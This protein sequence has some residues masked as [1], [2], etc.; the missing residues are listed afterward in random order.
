MARTTKAIFEIGAFRVSFGA[1]G[2]VLKGAQLVELEP[3]T[4]ETADLRIHGGRIVA[5]GQVT[6]EPGDEIIE[7]DGHWVMP[8]LVSAQHQLS[9]TLFRG[10]AREAGFENE[11]LALQRLQTSLELDDL[12]AAAAAGGLEG[13]MSGTTTVFDVT[14][15]PRCVL[16]SLTRV[17]HGLNDVGLR[18]VIACE[19]SDR[20]G[21]L[22]REESLDETSTFG[23]RARGRFRGALAFAH[24]GGISDDALYG[25]SSLLEVSKLFV[26]GS[27][28]E[29][30][31]EE[32]ESVKRFDKT[33]VKRLLEAG[34]IGPKTVLAQAVHVSW[35]DLSELLSAGAWLAHACRSNM[36]SRTGLASAAKF[37]VRG[38]LATHVMSLDLFGEAQAAWLRASDS[39]QPIDALRFLANGHRLASEVFGAPIGPLRE[40]AIADLLVL[41]YQA[42]T[43]VDET[44]LAAHV[45]TA[46]SARHVESV[47]VDGIWRLWKRTPLA[48]KPAEVARAAREAAKAVWARCAVA[49]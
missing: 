21:A 3:A 15:A 47:M 35:P 38:C 18:A 6:P 37:G 43:P 9:S 46:L 10:L 33:P 36:A 42:P 40:N 19:V 7:L 22:V 2:T 17:A 12:Q 4:V 48:L 28:A 31:R 39:G 29:D 41:D 11:H 8:G 26:L 1:V 14:A 13:L 49:K 23:P 5:R 20:Y 25:I 24:V 44:N 16:G 34:L 30:R 45:L 32:E 27:V